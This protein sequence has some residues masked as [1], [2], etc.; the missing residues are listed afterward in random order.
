VRTETLKHLYE[1]AE[2][3]VWGWLPERTRRRLTVYGLSELR[4][5]PPVARQ[6]RVLAAVDELLA[7]LAAEAAPRGRGTR[8]GGRFGKRDESSQAAT[9]TTRD[10]DR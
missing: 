4:S 2:L 3:R 8:P 6:R 10:G 5:W 7:A 1:R 9:P